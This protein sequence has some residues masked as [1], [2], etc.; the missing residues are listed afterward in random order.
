M[1]K[2]EEVSQNN[3]FPSAEMVLSLRNEF[4]ITASRGLE[5][6]MPDISK[7][8]VIVHPHVSQK[9]PYTPI[10]NFNEDYMAWKKSQTNQGLYKKNYIQVRL[11]ANK[12]YR[13]YLYN[14]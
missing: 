7:S 3:L 1:S 8:K 5:R 14:S 13:S 6:L 2:L 10:D 11:V 12:I 9:R 4:G